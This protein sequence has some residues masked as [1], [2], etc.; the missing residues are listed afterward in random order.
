MKSRQSRDT[1]FRME[2]ECRYVHTHRERGALSYRVQYGVELVRMA[3]Y[4]AENLTGK[5]IYDKGATFT[6][7]E[8]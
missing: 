2:H 6:R 3:K 1:N 8:S 5:A 4:G 7:R